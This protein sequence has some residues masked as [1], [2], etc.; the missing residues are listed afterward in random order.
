MSGLNEI[1]EAREER[2]RRIEAL[3]S[4]HGVPLILLS[5]NI[6]GPDKLIPRWAEIMEAGRHALLS[7]LAR[8]KISV[9]FQVQRTG[10]AGPE[11]Y[12][13]A[14]ADAVRLKR[15]CIRVEQEHPLGRVFDLDVH[16]VTGGQ[17]SRTGLGLP[18]RGCLMCDRPAHE[19]ARSGRHG[20]GELLNSIET[21]VFT[22]FFNI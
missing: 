1:L 20:Q 15:L 18:A 16:P 7:D 21:R 12:A 13:S 14:E 5:L 2:S 10:A 19:C 17:L 9:R 22:Y 6:P 8:E 11:W 3:R 4:A